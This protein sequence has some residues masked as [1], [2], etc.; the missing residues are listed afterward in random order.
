MMAAGRPRSSTGCGCS[1]PPWAKPP[2]EPSPT[3]T[4]SPP[5]RKARA[6]TWVRCGRT[7][8]WTGSW[9]PAGSPV[10]TVE[11]ASR[12]VGVNPNRVGPAVNAL[13]EAGV[14]E[15]RNVGRQRYRLFESPAVLDPWAVA[16]ADLVGPR[17][18]VDADPSG[19]D[20]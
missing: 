9:G 10:L 1:T 19:L 4:T 13:A 12:L 6:A 17:I 14:L 8:A 7:R 20:G 2:T 16:D 3:A 11:S 18:D 5:C 15:Q